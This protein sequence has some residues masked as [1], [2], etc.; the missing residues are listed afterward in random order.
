MIILEQ[1]FISAVFLRISL[2]YLLM[3]LVTF[4]PKLY[5]YAQG[6][7]EVEM[8]SLLTDLASNNVIRMVAGKRFYGEEND[9]SKLVRQLVSEVVA[10]AGAGNPA[11]YL[12]ILRWVTSFEKRIKNLGDRFD[13]FL[14]KLVDGKRAEKEKGQTLIDRLLSLQESQP[15]YYTDVLIKG[16][17]LVSVNQ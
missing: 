4:T 7:V 3:F 8:K 9:E 13:A 12:S 16:I 1:N 5:W 15:D 11:D 17:I 2:F 10:S 14:Q 6:F